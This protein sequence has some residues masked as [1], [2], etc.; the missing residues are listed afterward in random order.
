MNG[1]MDYGPILGE[2]SGRLE[3]LLTLVD[4]HFVNIA[5]GLRVLMYVAV[6]FLLWRVICIV[7]GLFAKVFFGGV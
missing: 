6:F 3:A 7:Y 5:A 2:I 4:R 1:G